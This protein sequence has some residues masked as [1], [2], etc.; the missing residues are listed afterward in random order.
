MDFEVCLRSELSLDNLFDGP[1]RWS[2]GEELRFG[3]G[4]G[5][6]GG[7]GRDRGR[8]NGGSLGFEGRLE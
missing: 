4:L 7:G 3:A 5:G 6:D 8:M 1:L 2:G